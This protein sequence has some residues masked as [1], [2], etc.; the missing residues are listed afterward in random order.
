MSKKKKRGL[1]QR[2]LPFQAHSETSA[3]AAQSMVP[4]APNLR[5]VVY[6]AIY[7]ATS[8]D[9]GLT[10]EEIVMRTGLNPSTVRPRRVEL[11]RDG[12]I[13]AA[14]K[15]P[16]ASGRMAMVWIARLDA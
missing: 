6:M 12:R 7:R 9:G 4:K 5:H 15:R 8:F 3:D 14:G 11:L 16:T 1:A 13:M 10:D 2:S